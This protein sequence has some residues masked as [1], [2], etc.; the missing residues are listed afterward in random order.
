[1][2]HSI[3]LILL[4]IGIMITDPLLIYSSEEKSSKWIVVDDVVMGGVSN[5][6]FSTN[7]DYAVFSGRVST[8]NNGGFS[9]IR[10]PIQSIDVSSKSQFHFRIKGDAKKYQFRVKYGYYDYESYVYEFKTTG[11]W[12]EIS[13]PFEFLKPRFR[14][15][16]LRGAAYDGSKLSEIGFL[17]G[18]K[19]NEDFELL[20]DWVH[21][22]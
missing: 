1:M 17:I 14:G 11:E 10:Y 22:E 8:A 12:E 21:V 4:Y 16:N 19:K 2:K 9:S 6:D 15:R 7:N 3:V 13:I 5:G 18:N 20:I